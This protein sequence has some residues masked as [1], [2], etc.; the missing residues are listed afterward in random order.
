MTT[1]RR[2]FADAALRNMPG[3]RSPA[4]EAKL[5]ALW[6]D[7]TRIDRGCV[8]GASGTR[9]RS[10]ILRN[11]ARIRAASGACADALANDAATSAAA[12]SSA[13]HYSFFLFRF[14]LKNSC[15]SPRHSSAITPATTVNPMVPARI[16]DQLQ[17]R[18]HRAGF[19]LGRA[20]NQ[21]ADARVHHGAD[22][23]RA[24]LDRHAERRARQP[25][26]AD[27]LRRGP[28]GANLG[29]RRRIDRRNRL[30]ERR[31]HDLAADRDDRADRH[32]V[33]GHRLAGFDERRAHQIFV[34]D[35][36]DKRQVT[37]NHEAFCIRSSCWPRSS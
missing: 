31:R 6:R 17:R 26:V 11:A 14:S 7:R 29:V 36:Q 30:I 16:V 2:S 35:R 20:V 33:A 22:A 3:T 19:R 28:N 15:S 34:G 37:M 1:G 21:R 13:C 32:L 8:S 4:S 10:I 27:R 5:N 9:G 24:R 12:S 25:V 23:H 18:E